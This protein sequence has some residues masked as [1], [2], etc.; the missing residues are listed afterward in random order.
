MCTP[1]KD[2]RFFFPPRT[3]TSNRS[4]L[5]TDQCLITLNSGCFCFLNNTL[6]LSANL[7]APFPYT[8][9]TPFT[10]STHFFAYAKFHQSV[11]V[12]LCIGSPTWRL[13]LKGGWGL[14][15]GNS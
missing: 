5:Q 15:T 8:T 6:W 12:N 13:L 11:L 10:K 3:Q 7:I 14:G 2:C 1:G 4:T 9:A